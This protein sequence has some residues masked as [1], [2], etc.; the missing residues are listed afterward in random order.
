MG[1]L[2]FLH[3]RILELLL[4]DVLDCASK[5]AS[6]A[7]GVG[8]MYANAAN[9]RLA[10]IEG[11]ERERQNQLRTIESFSSSGPRGILRRWTRN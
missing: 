6:R 8:E 9:E 1:N 3:D 5:L 11:L 10:V 2:V 7:V 4:P